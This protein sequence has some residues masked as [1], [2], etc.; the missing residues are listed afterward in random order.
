MRTIQV[1][2][3]NGVYSCDI[4]VTK[5]EWLEILKDTGTSENFKDALLRFYYM[6]GHRGS[7]TAV[8]NKM[9]GNPRALNILISKFGNRVQKH[10]KDRFE[11]IGVDGD[12]SRWIIPMN[13]GKR[14]SK[15]DEG[16]FEWELRS[17]LAEAIKEYLYGYLVEQYKRLRSHQPLRND[18]WDEL[19]K[20]ELI[21]VSRGKTAF[22]IVRDHVA[23]PSKAA[24][25]GFENLIDAVRDNK[26]LKY[27]VENKPSELNDVLNRLVDEAE[28]LD[29]RLSDYKAS[30]SALLPPSG[31]SS[32]ANDERTAA[33]ILTCFNPKKY[34]FY[35][36]RL[37]Y[38]R[39]CLFLG[40]L[41]QK[42]GQCYAHYLQLL[43]PLAQLAA[44]DAS[45]QAAVKEQLTGM[46][47]SDLLLAQDIVWM[48]LACG[49]K[50]RT[51]FIFD[52][53]FSTN[54]TSTDMTIKSKYEK[55]IQLLEANKNLI[56]TGAPGTG[57]TT[58]A[59]AIAE[60]MEAEVGF[61]QFHPSYDYTDFVEGLRPL[62]DGNGNVGFERRDGA[63]KGFCKKAQLSRSIDN[64]T[65]TELNDA[66]I[67]WKVSL[68]GTGDNP[69]RTDCLNNGY[70]RIGWDAYGDIED[71]NEFEDYTD[72]GRNVLRAFQSQMREGDIVVSCYT[73]KEIDAIGIVVGE[74]EFKKSGGRY[75]R[76]RAVKWLVKNIREEIIAQNAGKR[77]TLPAVY[78]SNISA[79]DALKIVQKYSPPTMKADDN[80]PFIFIIDEINRGEIS[81]IF[82]ELF[83]SIDPG[84]RGEK[85]KLQT[86]YQNMIEDGD[87]FKKGFFVPDNVYIIGTMND[88]DRS[89]ESMD[90]AMR[91]R[92]AWAEVT[93][94]ESYQNMIAES[95]DFTDEEKTAI[96]QRMFALNAAILKPELRLGEAYQ[97]GA[98]YFRKYLDYEEQGMDTAFEM[99][100][101]NHLK[102]LLFEY[103]RGNQNAKSQLVELK[104]A[105]DQKAVEHEEADKDNG[106]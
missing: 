85:G 23:H 88:I 104:K 58:I 20:W 99:L 54:K 29:K 96:K 69:I 53:L 64:H 78:K 57:K 55:Y 6:P 5:E 12:P 13:N 103:L 56:L 39:L 21:S 26:T 72:G 81:K 50:Q 38:E 22:E 36:Y 95:D 41:E 94:E 1:Q 67:V 33:S 17:E 44:N 3:T 31:Y 24:K 34:T 87:V 9:G 101:E 18:E 68:A 86:Q 15:D 91:R 2:N 89:V 37:M 52:I 8:G 48:L 27:L 47:K 4:G 106:Q 10:F 65:M 32:K 79:E 62:N 82:G 71:F 84:Y 16:S 14:L 83:F 42:T 11:V 25:G 92:F 19:Y 7:C 40:E 61:V 63:F 45:L 35:K 60:E 66:P 80:R 105:Y 74:Y 77:F 59:K 76:Y 30:M 46:V 75:P 51:G 70:V 90:F 98:A 49:D 73:A 28:T 97:I 43:A 93:A 100:W 102:G